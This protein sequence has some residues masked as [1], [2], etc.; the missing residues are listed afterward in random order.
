MSK[1][2]NYYFEVHHNI[3]L[4]NDYNSLDVPDN[5]VK[6]CPICHKC[7]KKMLVLNVSKWK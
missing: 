4:S 1:K 5:L 7:L 2:Y 3:A 6:L